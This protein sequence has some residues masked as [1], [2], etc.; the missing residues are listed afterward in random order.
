MGDR[1]GRPHE[2][3]GAKVHC[4]HPGVVLVL[5]GEPNLRDLLILHMFSCKTFPAIHKACVVVGEL[6][7]PVAKKINKNKLNQK[8]NQRWLKTISCK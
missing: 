6:L 4:S 1:P 5:G 3:S 7:R 8:N 2:L